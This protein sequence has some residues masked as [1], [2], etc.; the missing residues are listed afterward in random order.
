M[1]VWA[2]MGYEEKFT[3]ERAEYTPDQ[4]NYP[5]E[6]EHLSDG[7]P[8]WLKMPQVT[9]LHL[10][11]D[12][13][14]YSSCS[15]LHWYSSSSLL[16]WCMFCMC[17]FKIQQYPDWDWNTFCTLLAQFL[18]PA[19]CWKVDL[20]EGFGFYRAVKMNSKLRYTAK[21]TNFLPAGSQ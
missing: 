17:N 21:S 12:E 8:K 15:L 7:S 3:C 18:E 1:H 10:I 9:Q 6:S 5:W 4:F 16:H 20:V 2:I 13:P 19:R 14:E 11:F